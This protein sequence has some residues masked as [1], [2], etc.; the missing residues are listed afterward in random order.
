MK[1]SSLVEIYDRLNETSK[2]LEKIEIISEFVIDR[3]PNISMN[4]QII[5]H[6]ISYEI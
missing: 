5:L 1:Y 6:E 3:I 4:L 2:R